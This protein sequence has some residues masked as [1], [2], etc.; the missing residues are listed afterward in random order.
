[1]TRKLDSCLLLALALSAFAWLPLVTPG[2][3][4]GAHDAP[5]S[6]FFLQ[7]FD[8]VL[9]DGHWWPAW[10]P[11][12]AF[13]YGYPLW[14]FYAPLAYYVG[15]AFHLLGASITTAMK[16]V[17]L[18]ATVGATVS[19]YL[20]ARHHFGKPAAALAAVVYTVAPY[21]L[22]DLYVRSSGAEYFAFVFFPLV[23]WR[24]EVLLQL[25]SRRNAVLAAVVTAGLIL[26]HQGA[27]FIFAILLA[28]YLLFSL[29][30]LL[31]TEDG[32]RETVN[33]ARPPS[34]VRRLAYVFVAAL[35]TL[36]LSAIF[37]L[38]LLLEQ[39][40]IV[41]EQWTSVA[42]NYQKHFVFTNQF[43][44]PFWGYGYSGEGLEDGIGFQLGLM[45]MVGG[46]VALLSLRAKRSNP[47]TPVG[48]C[49][50]KP[51][52]SVVEGNARNDMRAMTVFFLIASIVIALAMSP[53]S[54][55]FWNA[56]PLAS[57]VQFPWRLLAL[58]T[59]TLAWLAGAA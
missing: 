59:I 14:I 46:I 38:P 24:W 43:F 2:Y 29:A 16:L 37:W 11:H 26:T 41:V 12:F 45:P 9:R 49:F 35:L 51:V 39:K 13:G 5:H 7:A 15:E 31:R 18:V 57:L 20:W 19:M 42:Y 34:V 22:L 4:M 58:S 54:A 40:Y 52:L 28:A 53:V 23:L 17:D 21:H 8:E 55:T 44:S 50:A 3:F 48:D 30:Q 1:M 10:G 47:L 33:V 27:A 25:P 36:G 56:V 32:G 6:L